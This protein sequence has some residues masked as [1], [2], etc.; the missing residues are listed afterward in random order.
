M[1]ELSILSDHELIT[2]LKQDRRSAFQELYNRYWRTLYNDAY[3]R[4]KDK[5]LCEEVV[6]EVFINLWQKREGIQ[7][8]STVGGYLHTAVS[9]LVIDFF[10]K[11]SV[12][13]RYRE[14]YK[15]F[16]SEVDDTTQTEIDLRELSQTIAAEVSRLPDKCRSVYELSRKEHKS[17]KEIARELSISEKTVENHITNALRK[18]RL[19]LG[20]Y[21]LLILLLVVQ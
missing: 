4:L 2:L 7:I 9:N 14:H 19:S 17:N 6:Q 12:R 20:H 15:L 5:Q 16:N 8:N 3:K 18:L 10:R 11:D 1:Q 21:L 13:A